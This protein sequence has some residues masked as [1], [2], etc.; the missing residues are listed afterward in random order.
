MTLFLQQGIFLNIRTVIIIKRLLKESNETG[1]KW[2]LID[3]ISHKQK[4]NN[5]WSLIISVLATSTL[6]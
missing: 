5:N 4:K 2:L 1:Y 6:N 3:P